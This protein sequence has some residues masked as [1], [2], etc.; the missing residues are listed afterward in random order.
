MVYN[1]N[2][3]HVGDF[4]A[5]GTLSHMISSNVAKIMFLV[6]S[7]ILSGYNDFSRS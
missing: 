6:K 2:S 7:G 1:L 4:S 3:E 5:S